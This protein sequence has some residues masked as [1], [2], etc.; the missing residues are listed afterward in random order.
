MMEV[1]ALALGL[2]C[3]AL[4]PLAGWLFRSGAARWPPGSRAETQGIVDALTRARSVH[5]GNAMPEHRAANRRAVQKWSLKR[6]GEQLRRWR[7]A[8]SIERSGAG[9][10]EAGDQRASKKRAGGCD[11]VFSTFRWRAGAHITR[12]ELEDCGR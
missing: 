5:I 6:R 12:A 2:G 11:E 7:A 10:A 4:R 3:L 9:G 8:W 1:V